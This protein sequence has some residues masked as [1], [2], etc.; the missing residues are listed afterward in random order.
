[1]SSLNQPNNNEKEFQSK[2]GTE[3]QT[4]L[5]VV[6]ELDNAKKSGEPK[7]ITVL[8]KKLSLQKMLIKK[9][10]EENCFT[11]RALSR[12]M[13]DTK[14]NTSK[15]SSY[16]TSS[17]Y[18]FVNIKDNENKSYSCL[19]SKLKK[20]QSTNFVKNIFVCKETKSIAIQNIKKSLNIEDEAKVPFIHIKPKK[21]NNTCK[22]AAKNEKIH[23]AKSTVMEIKNNKIKVLHGQSTLETKTNQ[24]ILKNII[25]EKL[26]KKKK[27]KL[28]KFNKKSKFFNA[29]L[30]RIDSNAKE[31]F[32]HTV[33]GPP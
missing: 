1:M 23:L 30:V 21:Q 2:I 27:S 26:F 11:N 8:Q 12:P 19:F 24:L 7:I 9:C 3:C 33:T 16:S 14:A 25:N 31:N 29:S 32:H 4:L 22:I 20:V 15:T 17:N 28:L 6:Q 5:L 18:S 10:N 13:T